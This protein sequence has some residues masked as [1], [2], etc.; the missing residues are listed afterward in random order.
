MARITFKGLLMQSAGTIRL[1][2]PSTVPADTGGSGNTTTTT[3][4][5]P[6]NTTPPTGTGSGSGNTGSGG[7]G[8]GGGTPPTPPSGAVVSLA[9]KPQP[10]IQVNTPMPT[11]RI[12]LAGTAT[13]GYARL[14]R[15]DQPEGAIVAFSNAAAVTGLPSP[16]YPGT[17]TIRAFSDAAATVK[18]GESAPVTVWVAATGPASASKAVTNAPAS[19]TRGV[20]FTVS[21]TAVTASNYLL[22]GI[23]S[24]YNYTGLY[25]GDTEAGYTAA[26]VKP[27]G[28]WS[29]T[30][31]IDQAY[32]YFVSIIDPS[33]GS[34]QTFSGG[35]GGNI[36]A[37]QAPVGVVRWNN[38]INTLTAPNKI[39]GYFGF[40]VGS[41]SPY[42]GGAASIGVSDDFKS[43]AYGRV[44]TKRV[45]ASGFRQI[46]VVVKKSGQAD[47]TLNVPVFVPYSV[48]PTDAQIEFIQQPNDKLPRFS[49]IGWV[50][51][52]SGDNAWISKIVDPSF[53][54]KVYDGRVI[55]W[56]D[57]LPAGD[58]AVKLRIVDAGLVLDVPVV[59]P[60]IAATLLA[61]AA[62]SYTAPATLANTTSPGTAIGAPTVTG[63]PANGQWTVIQDRGRR[64]SMD[65]ATGTLG[66]SK[67]LS[68]I[69]GEPVTLVYNAGNVVASKVLT[70]PVNAPDGPIL[71]V[72]AG[73]TYATPQDALDKHLTDPMGVYANAVM[74]IY[75]GTY[76][77]PISM[78]NGPIGGQYNRGEIHG[79]LK[80]R[81]VKDSNGLLPLLK[82][83]YTLVFAKDKGFF[84]GQGHDLW[85]ENLEVSNGR[86]NL[87]N[88]DH[89][90]NYFVQVGD[91]DANNVENA[92]LVKNCLVHDCEDGVGRGTLGAR[93]VIEDTDFYFNCDGAGYC[94][95]LYA[96]GAYVRT[97][98]V[99][100][101]GGS[102]GHF[103]KSRCDA[104]VIED[105]RFIATNDSSPGGLIDVC[106]G[107]DLTMTG[108]EAWGGPNTTNAHMVQYG[109]EMDTDG[110]H[111]SRGN[112]VRL[113]NNKLYNLVPGGYY[114]SGHN[115][116][117][118]I[119]CTYNV[120][121]VNN[122]ETLGPADFVVTNTT[123]LG[124]TSSQ[125]FSDGYAV[126]SA[127]NASGTVTTGSIPSYNGYV[128]AGSLRCGAS[129]F[130]DTHVGPTLNF[131]TDVAYSNT[132]G[133]PNKAT[134]DQ[135]VVAAFIWTNWPKAPTVSQTASVG[136]FVAKASMALQNIGSDKG[137]SGASYTFGETTPKGNDPLLAVAGDGTMT[138]QASLAGQAGNV[139]TVGVDSVDSSGNHHPMLCSVWVGA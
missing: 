11:L 80:V 131:Y 83:D 36:S 93:I 66:I 44:L 10:W 86:R 63:A 139:V 111:I 21:G 23:R 118:G 24:P 26:E 29:G 72:G 105:C 136:S 126:A 54:F 97:T 48:P 3:P 94:H 134:T 96:L 9:L 38:P 73:K 109:A 121:P 12:L 37:D 62:I 53:S 103:W 2:R 16:L 67:Y 61:G 119:V 99:T 133:Y 107:G 88:G 84:N 129:G 87:N 81:G 106:D 17:Y 89:S 28:T 14:Y 52:Y 69:T 112:R 15:F 116:P 57:N 71:E 32:P 43:D 95:H 25:G 30:S 6:G 128:G 100:F 68:G 49:D 101:V 90:F 8:S 58:Y 120:N 113:D 13:G 98:R 46:P 115:Q 138:V 70:I 41:N 42:A 18:I 127:I 22:F 102:N 79:P 77:N 55:T 130:R 34:E 114:P 39:V 82:K 104:N 78:D 137:V 108:C 75:P 1:L 60:V 125:L 20:P 7:S 33:T 123:M 64:L 74:L 19:V 40:T 124:L 110:G 45:L 85:I 65:V 132:S 5:P 51:S 76:I 47:L 31:K 92:L 27:D 50:R 135:G 59:I 35:T 56:K 122:R 117:S 4:P 91:K